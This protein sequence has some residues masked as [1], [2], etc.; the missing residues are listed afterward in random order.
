MNLRKDST[1]KVKG[2][3]ECI[4]RKK[5]ALKKKGW[6]KNH[7]PKG[8]GILEFDEKMRILREVG[9]AKKNKPGKEDHRKKQGRERKKGGEPPQGM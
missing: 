5:R 9:E 8:T 2:E 3:G 7:A 6:W 4:R 1:K